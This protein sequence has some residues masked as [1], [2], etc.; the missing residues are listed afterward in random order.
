[1]LEI[2]LPETQLFDPKTNRFSDRPEVKLKLEHS[3]L[4]V[5]KWESIHKKPFFNEV[6]KTAAESRSY[7]ECMILGCDFC[8]EAVGR[9]TMDQ[10]TMINDY[11]TES[12]TATTIKRQGPGRSRELVTS[13]LIYYWMVALTIPFEA[14]SWHLSRLLTLIEI[15][16]VKN[17]P[18]KKMSRS[19][20]AS[21]QRSLN[22]QRKAALNTSG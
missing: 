20:A 11:I 19:E 6:D 14:E 10:M 5:S 15:C 3:L 12:K 21:R 17:Q 22:A 8:E 2:N 18:K 16:A 4:S 1:M 13:E 7:V 9:L